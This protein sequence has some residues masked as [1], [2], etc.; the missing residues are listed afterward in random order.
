VDY[1]DGY[2]QTSSALAFRLRCSDRIIRPISLH[3][4]T[5][6]SACMLKEISEW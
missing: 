1:E 2:R 5:I 6:N 4:M 3:V